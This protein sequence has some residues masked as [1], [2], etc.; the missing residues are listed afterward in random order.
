MGRRAGG[1]GVLSQHNAAPRSTIEH[2][3]HPEHLAD[4]VAPALPDAA[5]VNHY[6]LFDQTISSSTGHKAAE[7]G[8]LRTEALAVCTSCPALAPCRKWLNTIPPRQRP[9][10]VVAG[11]VN[12]RRPPGYKPTASA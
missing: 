9:S 11:Q 6:E 1:L 3:L 10:G 4:V 7:L 5:C 2:V 8:A 12:T